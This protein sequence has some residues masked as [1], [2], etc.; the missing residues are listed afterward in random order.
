MQS[1][2]W[3]ITGIKWQGGCVLSEVL[4]TSGV[5]YGQRWAGISQDLG[6]ANIGGIALGGTVGGEVGGLADENSGL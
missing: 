6:S 4:V 1:I 2:Q 5:F 3:Q